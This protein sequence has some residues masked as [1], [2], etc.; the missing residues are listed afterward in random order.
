MISKILGNHRLSLLSLALLITS[1]H[2]EANANRLRFASHNVL[3][4]KD[5]FQ[6]KVTGKVQSADGPLAG[7]TISVRGTSRSTSAGT[8]G[9]FSIE[10]KNGDVLVVNS[11]G[12]K[13]QEVTVKSPVININLVLDDEALDEVVVTGYSRQKKTEVSASVVSIDQKTLKD[14]KSPNVSTLLQSKIAGVD[15]VSGSGRP[16]SNANIRVRGRNSINSNISPLWVVDGVIMHGTPNINPNDIETVSVLKDAAATT[17]YGSRGAS[18]VIV[19][20][21]KRALKPGEHLFSFNLSSGISKF[22]PGKFKVMDSQQM[23]DLYQSFNNQNAIPNSI[24]SDVLNTDFDWLENGTQNGGI[25]DFSAN[26]LGK[27]EETSIYASGNY[28]DEKGSVK[29]YDYNRL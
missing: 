23:W 13:G 20:T 11:I 8:D 27:T 18:G 28:Y 22:N 9:S 24:N 10:A 4:N 29:G 19:V 25:N 7:A 15:V 5:V 21:T 1:T 2:G 12:Y 14:V 16:G 26:Y 17:Q 6:Q 3:S